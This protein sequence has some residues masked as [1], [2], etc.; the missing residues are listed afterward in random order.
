MRT[1]TVTAG[2]GA[3]PQLPQRL[4]APAGGERLGE[5]GPRGNEGAFAG[6]FERP[7]RPILSFCRHMLG[8]REEAED[9]VQHTFAAAYSALLEDQREIRLKPW[10]Y[11]IAR[12][13][14]LSVLRARREQASD[15]LEVETVGLQ[16]QVQRR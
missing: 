2:R 13:R 8:S 9:A 6:G 14:C 1:V 3:R 7:S 12:N 11:A 10:L 16:E 15:E 5:Q 4:L